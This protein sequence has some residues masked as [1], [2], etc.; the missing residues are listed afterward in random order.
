MDGN[1]IASIIELYQY[2]DNEVGVGIPKATD[3]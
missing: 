1:I 2:E 3:K